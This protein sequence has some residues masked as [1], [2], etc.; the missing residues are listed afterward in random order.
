MAYNPYLQFGTNQDPYNQQ[1]GSPFGNADPN[2][3][4]GNNP[5]QSSAGEGVTGS[6]PSNNPFSGI[7]A[8]N[9]VGGAI[10]AY[11]FFHAQKQLD[12]LNSTPYPTYAESPELSRAYSQAESNANTGF[13]PGEKNAYQ[14]SINQQG[15]T[16][17]QRAVGAG[18]GDL[19][20][21]VSAGINS[22]QIAGEG[23]MSIAD[24]NIRR[25]N[26]QYAGQLAGEV[27]QQQNLA[28]TAAIKLREQ[29]LQAL[30][31]SQ[32]AGL[33]SFMNSFNVSGLLKTGVNAAAT[34]AFV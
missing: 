21:V 2:Y 16:A 32:T 4:V 27:Q 7:G 25:Q 3:S 14:N 22:Q 5:Y 23:Q 17:Y 11:E 18:G 33:Q 19:S 34:A 8:G 29:Q 31:A 9:L 6:P 28:S 13:L 30:N 10:G 24:A 15:A 12:A 1:G 26:E 20:N